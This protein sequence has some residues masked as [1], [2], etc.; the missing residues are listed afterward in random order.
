[1]AG[2]ALAPLSG[3]AVASRRGKQGWIPDNHAGRWPEFQVPGF[4]FQ[5]FHPCSH[6]PLPNAFL[7]S[8]PVAQ[9]VLSL[10]FD[11]LTTL[12]L[13][14]GSKGRPVESFSVSGGFSSPSAPLSLLQA[15]DQSGL[16]PFDD[17]HHSHVRKQPV[18]IVFPNG[19]YKALLLF[20]LL[21]QARIS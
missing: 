7:C 17:N 16:A 15:V 20:R 11:R 8:C 18:M 6:A 3:F 9:P 2:C 1:M 12:S 14:E 10:W 5:V 21:T 19:A 4:R 13:V